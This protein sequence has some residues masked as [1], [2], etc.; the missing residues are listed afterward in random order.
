MNDEIIAGDTGT[1]FE[2]TIQDNNSIVDIRGASIE[3]VIKYKS[4]RTIKQGQVTDGINGICEIIL[5]SSDVQDDGIYSF[6]GTV[7]FDSGKK[8]SSDIHRFSVAKKL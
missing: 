5:E 7:T 6:Q 2:F 3:V 1:V 4:K 8:F